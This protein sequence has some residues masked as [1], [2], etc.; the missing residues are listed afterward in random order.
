VGGAAGPVLRCAAACAARASGSAAPPGP[1]P[2]HHTSPLPHT[3]RSLP[4]SLRKGGAV[5][6]CA[7]PPFACNEAGE[8]VHFI[9]P[10][11]GLSCRGLPD[12]FRDLKALQ[13]LDLSGN[14]LEDS[15]EHVAEVVSGLKGLRRLY[16]RSSGLSGALGCDVLGP[17][18]QVGAR[19]AGA[20]WPGWIARAGQ[21]ARRRPA[22]GHVPSRTGRAHTP[23]RLLQVLTMSTNQIQG[24]I[25]ACFISSNLTEL[26]LSLNPKLTGPLPDNFGS[27]KLIVFYA[28]NS[29]LTGGLQVV[30]GGWSSGRRAP[31][32][33]PRRPSPGC[34][35]SCH[36]GPRHPF[37]TLA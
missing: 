34:C 26:Y 35:C 27:S 31:T 25:P 29:S 5:N 28:L 16:L 15:T 14:S 17:R 37:C 1:A 18:L 21:L 11:A 30:Q 22:A 32:L 9:A 10:N 8:L 7:Q 4:R 23:C 3:P 6:L 20:A 33:L 19:A 13:S 2:P 12:A 24:T 36:A